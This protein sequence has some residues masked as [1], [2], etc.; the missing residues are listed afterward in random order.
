MVRTVKLGRKM[1]A[2]PVAHHWAVKAGDCWYEVAGASKNDKGAN[3]II[4]RYI[5]F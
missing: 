4:K 5:I 1:L 3:M 2:G